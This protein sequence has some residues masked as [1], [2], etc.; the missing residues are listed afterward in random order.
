M[1]RPT[2]VNTATA[3]SGSA[4]SVQITL[5]ALTQGN[6][7]L[8]AC[9][10]DGADSI[11]S[12]DAGWASVSGSH[13]TPPSGGCVMELFQKVVGASEPT[14]P[15][16]TSNRIDAFSVIFWQLD[17]NAELDV[18][19]Q[20]A[21]ADTGAPDPA[22]ITPVSAESLAIVALAID[23]D[24]VSSATMTNYTRDLHRP[25]GIQNNRVTLQGYSR[26][27]TGT[28]AED[29]PAIST[30][31]DNWVAVTMAWAE[32][33]ASSAGQPTWTRRGGLW[34]PRGGQFR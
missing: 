2:I 12:A 27:L 22:S 25:A 18:A 17:N 20:T 30:G 28:S 29:P 11:F 33:V 26:A 10:Q 15:T 4:N 1:A 5:P 3:N 7:M 13:L 8:V 6:R 32:A 9:A 31:D 19:I 16:F 21:T 34:H 24:D 23:R 14:D